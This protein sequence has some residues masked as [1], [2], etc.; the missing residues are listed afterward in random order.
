MSNDHDHRTGRRRAGLGRACAAG[1]VGL[2]A[3]GSALTAGDMAAAI[4]LAPTWLKEYAVRSFGTHDKAVLVT[5]ILTVT[6]LLA[7]LAGLIALRRPGPGAAAVGPFG[8]VGIWAAASRP[9]ARAAD[10]YPSVA[11]GLTDATVLWFL[12]RSLRSATTRNQGRSGD[13][14]GPPGDATPG[15][16]R[17]TVL[18]ATGP[19]T[20]AAALG[21]AAGR[22][23]PD[24]RTDVGPAVPDLTAFGTPTADRSRIDTTLTLPGIDSRSWSLRIHGL[25]ASRSVPPTRAAGPDPSPADPRS[26]PVRRVGTTPSSPLSELPGG[27]RVPSLPPPVVRRPARR[28]LPRPRPGRLQQQRHR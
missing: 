17:R 7:T 24:S 22:R 21:A 26:R 28:R 19:T 14:P 2:A 12:A 25:V 23:L 4:D 15:R 10:T 27:S 6:A 18:G 11:A 3:T 1:A 20:G 9:T 5:G 16:G 8:T 13:R